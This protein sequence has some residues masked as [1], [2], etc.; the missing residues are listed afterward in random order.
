MAW[1]Q[2]L[3]WP[4]CSSVS[5]PICHGVIVIYKV[6]LRIQ[7]DG[8]YV[9]QPCCSREATSDH[10]Q[11]PQ[12]AREAKVFWWTHSFMA[13][14][15]W[16]AVRPTEENCTPEVTQGGQGQ[17]QPDRHSGRLAL[18]VDKWLDFHRVACEIF[19]FHTVLKINLAGGRVSQRRSDRYILFYIRWLIAHKCSQET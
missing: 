3:A 7:W 5:F 2:S 4:H 13:N 14:S 1:A 6:A 12:R 16:A 17:R 11:G 19:S 9:P 15:E 8:M 18:H 10:G